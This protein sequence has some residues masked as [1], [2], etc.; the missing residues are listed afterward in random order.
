MYTLN[1]HNNH[2]FLKGGKFNTE[3]ITQELEDLKLRKHG[4]ILE[5]AD[6]LP[7]LGNKRERLGLPESGAW[8]RNPQGLTLKPGAVT[9]CSCCSH[10]WA[11]C[12]KLVLEQAALL[13]QGELCLPGLCWPATARS[14]CA[15]PA[16]WSPFSA[17]FWQ[18]LSGI[19]VSKKGSLQ[20]PNECVKLI[21]Q[22][23]YILHFLF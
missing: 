4:G 19:M 3:L 14:R 18:N 8:R 9:L 13:S 21:F 1:K 6:I 23:Y 5:E 16:F 12:R 22:F 15:F 7:H 10:L 2:Y 20:G 17:T 11:C